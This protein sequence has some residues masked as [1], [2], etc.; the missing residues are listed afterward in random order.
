MLQPELAG[1]RSHH[2]LPVVH[3]IMVSLN[4]ASVSRMLR[5]VN[6]I[7]VQLCLLTAFCGESEQQERL[8]L[9]RHLQKQQQVLQLTLVWTVGS[10]LKITESGLMCID[11]VIAAALKCR[12]L[13][14]SS[15]Q[16]SSWKT[17]GFSCCVISIAISPVS[18]HRSQDVANCLGPVSYHTNSVPLLLFVPVVSALMP[19]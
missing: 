7:L 10:T 8:N 16:S 11:P 5:V 1:Q 14:T 18:H 17:E 15:T 4:T 3:Y 12:L 9:Q 13:V 19:S 6:Q 2:M